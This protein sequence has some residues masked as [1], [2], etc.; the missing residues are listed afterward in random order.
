MLKS[1]L[2]IAFWS[3]VLSVII[4]IVIGDLVVAWIRTILRRRGWDFA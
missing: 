4:A 2:S 1:I 3:D